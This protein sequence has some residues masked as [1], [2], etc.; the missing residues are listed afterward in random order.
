MGNY[1]HRTTLARVK[2]GNDPD[3]PSETWLSETLPGVES[4]IN[5]LDASGVPDY[6][7]KVDGDTVREWTD[8]EK[9]TDIATHKQRKFGE[10]VGAV[11]VYGI[12]H[13]S[14]VDEMRLS[15]R[16]EEAHRLGLT[17]RAAY[18]TTAMTWRDSVLSEYGA[19]AATIFAATTIEAIEAVSMD[20]SSFDV[21]DP[22]VTLTV[23]LGITN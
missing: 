3:Y 14:E 8:A 6:W 18:I 2:S 19:R 15:V 16:L 13:Y 5:A 20:F 23:A 22:G 21:S 10:L 17:N 9:L 1:I 11:N 12:E 4:A 7:R